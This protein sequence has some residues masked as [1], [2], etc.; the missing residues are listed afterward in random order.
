MTRSG[1]G[2]ARCG[3]MSPTK[4]ITPLKET[5]MAVES[6]DKINTVTRRNLTLTPSELL[7]SSS[8][9]MASSERQ[10]NMVNSAS[11]NNPNRGKRQISHFASPK[12]PIDQK[13]ILL[14]ER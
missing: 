8:T 3:T 12:P 2:F 10:R 14:A 6:A 13:R 7:V 1:N 9:N 11:D 5:K 4:P